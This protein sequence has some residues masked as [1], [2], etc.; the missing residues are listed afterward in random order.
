MPIIKK[1]ICIEYVLVLGWIAP[2]I[3][4]KTD[5]SMNNWSGW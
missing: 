2:E 3:D 1:V 5:L 4:P